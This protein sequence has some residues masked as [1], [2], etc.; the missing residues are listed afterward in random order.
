MWQ[1]NA[2]KL[3][4]DL[5]DV[6]NKHGGADAFDPADPAYIR[7]VVDLVQQTHDQII[8][9]RDA[10]LIDAADLDGLPGYLDTLEALLAVGNGVLAGTATHDDAITWN[11]LVAK[12]LRGYTYLF[13]EPLKG[14]IN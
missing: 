5:Y 1:A 13:D 2:S 7:E 14:P 12:V 6:V 4:T 3:S 10:D 11:P 8:A 9:I